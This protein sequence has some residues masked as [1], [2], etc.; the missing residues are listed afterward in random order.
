MLTT[1]MINLYRQHIR[2]PYQRTFNKIYLFLGKK[3]IVLGFEQICNTPEVLNKETIT[4]KCN[5][6][7]Y[8]REEG[9]SLGV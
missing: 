3:D 8:Y 4:L 9:Y 6:Y 7:I 1:L 2:S 5:K